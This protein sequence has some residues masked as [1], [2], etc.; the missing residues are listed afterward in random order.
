MILRGK[1]KDNNG[2][3]KQHVQTTKGVFGNTD[4]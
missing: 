1:E 2:G 3:C 4:I